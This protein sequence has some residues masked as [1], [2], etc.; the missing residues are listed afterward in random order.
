MIIIQGTVKSKVKRIRPV[1]AEIIITDNRGVDYCLQMKPKNFDKLI[2]IDVGGRVEFTVQNELSA[3]DKIRIN[4][5]TVVD[6]IKI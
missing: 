1:R 4:N 5:L 6:A 2:Q 3:T